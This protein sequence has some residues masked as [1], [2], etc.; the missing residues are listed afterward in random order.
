M[1]A[2]LPPFSTPLLSCHIS[3]YPYNWRRRQDDDSQPQEAGTTTTRWRTSMAGLLRRYSVCRMYVAEKR[4]G[5]VGE[6]IWRDWTHS[7][8]GMAVLML[9]EWIDRIA[10]VTC[11][12][13]IHVLYVSYASIFVSWCRF[14]VVVIFRV[15]CFCVVLIRKT[16]RIRQN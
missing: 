1:C 16:W 9:W 14:M 6:Q 2:I 7:G 11:D 3:P 12:Y 10:L 4:T 13:A 8:E 15:D 5:A